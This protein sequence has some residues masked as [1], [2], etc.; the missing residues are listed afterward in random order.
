M[1]YPVTLATEQSTVTIKNT[2]TAMI[3]VTNLKITG[4][5]SVYAA[6]ADAAESSA[7]PAAVNEAVFAPVTLQSLRLAANGVFDTDAQPI[8]TDPPAGDADRPGWNADADSAPA[9]MRGLMRALLDSLSELFRDLPD[10]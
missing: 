5:Q 4:V 10:W 7:A 8:E 1:Y 9:L 6:A 3:A 2:G